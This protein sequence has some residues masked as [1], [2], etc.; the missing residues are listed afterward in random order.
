M[1]VGIVGLGLIGGSMAKAYKRV[2]HTILA[3][4]IDETMLDFA[5]LEGNV[6]KKL[7]D[8]TISECDLI[9]IALYP[10]ACIDF[11]NNNAH[12]IKP[13][14]TVIDCCGTKQKICECGFELAAKY[15][16]TFFGGHPMAGTHNSG[17]KF[18]SADLFV[19]APMVIVPERYDDIKMF[20]K[21]KQLLSPCRFGSFA[22]TTAKEHDKTIAFTSQMPHIISNG[23]IKSPNAKVHKGFSAGSYK[24]LTRVAWLNPKMW[25]ELFFENKNF[26]L[27]EL[28]ILINNLND[29][30]SALENNDKDKMISLLDEGRKIKEEV[31]GNDRN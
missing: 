1:N 24:D 27:D 23:F 12:L 8:K 30:K 9:I 16:F 29:Y 17:Y 22:V 2:G 25:T 6:D 15:G 13:E 4:D 26:V 28:D 31:D 7:N 18:S 5:C 3:F 10:D 20:D 11:L 19:D 14:S 21:A